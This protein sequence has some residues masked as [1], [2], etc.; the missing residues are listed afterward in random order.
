MTDP[1]SFCLLVMHPNQYIPMVYCNGG[2]SDHPYQCLEGT[3]ILPDIVVGRIS[4]RLAR[5]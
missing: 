3:D 4:F 1:N 5:T 2:K